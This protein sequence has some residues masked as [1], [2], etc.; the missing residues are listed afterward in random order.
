MVNATRE[1]SATELRRSGEQGFN[2]VRHT[3]GCLSLAVNCTGRE[4]TTIEGL[5][6]PGELS[7][8]QQAFLDTGA[9][10]RGF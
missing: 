9:V 6:P 10:Q 5:A 3:S 4:I 1:A 8:V 7:P 2:L